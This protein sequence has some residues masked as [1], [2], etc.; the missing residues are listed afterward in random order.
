[1]A[2]LHVGEWTKVWCSNAGNLFDGG[3]PP[4]GASGKESPANAADLNPG[5]MPGS[6]GPLEEEMETHSNILAW[7]I[8]CTEEPDRL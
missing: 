5:L 2:L 8:P 7:D 3:E 1:M 4:G 6:G